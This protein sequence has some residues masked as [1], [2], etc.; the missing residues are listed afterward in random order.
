MPLL[1]LGEVRVG[2]APFFGE[3]LSKIR[4]KNLEGSRGA[5]ETAQRW[6]TTAQRK[7]EK[8]W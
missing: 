3:L 7:T 6:E 2:I 4:E 1:R 8:L 5:R